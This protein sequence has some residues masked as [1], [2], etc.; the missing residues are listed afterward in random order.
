ML[1]SP[2]PAVEVE[3]LHP[4]QEEEKKVLRETQP[5]AIKEK[6]KLEPPMV[7]YDQQNIG[8]DWVEVTDSH[9][10]TYY[11]NTKSNAT[12]WKRPPD[13]TPLSP[14]SVTSQ[15]NQPRL[16]PQEVKQEPLKQ[17]KLPPALPPAL[18]RNIQSEQAESQAATSQQPQLK[19]QSA[20]NTNEDTKKFLPEGWTEHYDA[21]SNRVYYYHKATN[22]TTW[23]RPDVQEDAYQQPTVHIF[24]YPNTTIYIYIYIHA[25]KN[26]HM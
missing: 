2:A 19:I 18:H 11:W 7:W 6:Q 13:Q 4:K 12:S 3:I 10:K 16:G 14:G 5:L 15:S 23:D 25:F 21:P 22:K 9:G 20:V 8:T 24:P 17:N 26:P 1:A